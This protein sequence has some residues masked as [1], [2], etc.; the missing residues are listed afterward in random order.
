[1]ILAGGQKGSKTIENIFKAFFYLADSF[2]ASCIAALGRNGND[3]TA[4]KNT[5]KLNVNKRTISE[6]GAQSHNGELAVLL[7]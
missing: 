4:K 3:R 1:M 2:A 7:Y 6:N 5:A